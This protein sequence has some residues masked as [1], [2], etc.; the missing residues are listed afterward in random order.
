[1][2]ADRRAMAL[3]VTGAA[4]ALT[5]C[6]DD[7]GGER[8][9]TSIQATATEFSFDPDTWAVPAGQEFAIELAND[10]T[11]E[12]EWAVV[13]LG[14]DIEAEDEFAEEIVLLEVEAIAAGSSTTQSFTIDDAGAYQVICAIAGHLDAGMEGSLTVR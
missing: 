14:A 7:D 11:V 9:S 2:R 1:M 4:A 6:A 12:H 10:G 5:G 3:L 13:K 8:S